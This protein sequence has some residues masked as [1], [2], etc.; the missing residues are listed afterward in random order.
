MLSITDTIDTF[1]VTNKQS[2]LLELQLNVSKYGW[3]W[4][5][6]GDALFNYGSKSDSI[7]SETLSVTTEQYMFLHMLFIVGP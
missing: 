5:H 6:I 7:E 1:Q 4:S 3:S 2:I